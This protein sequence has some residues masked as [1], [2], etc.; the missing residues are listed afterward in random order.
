MMLCYIYF[1]LLLLPLSGV[2]GGNAW[3]MAHNPPSI[4]RLDFMDALG[5]VALDE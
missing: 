5:M 4:T 2:Q 1:T 3:R